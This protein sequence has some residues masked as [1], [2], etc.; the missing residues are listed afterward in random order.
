M[1]Q[2]RIQLN[3]YCVK[4][5]YPDNFNGAKFVVSDRN[6]GLS[7]LERRKE[8]TITVELAII[9]TKTRSDIMRLLFLSRWKRNVTK[10]HIRCMRNTLLGFR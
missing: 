8:S 1:R 5:F 10:Y 4:M 9:C 3:P 6:A 2:M 7:R